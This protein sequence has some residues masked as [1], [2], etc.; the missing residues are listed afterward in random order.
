MTKFKKTRDQLETELGEQMLALRASSKAFDEG[1]LWEHKRLATSLFTLLHDYPGGRSK[2]LLGQLQLKGQVKFISSVVVPGP[3]FPGNRVIAAASTLIVATKLSN[4]GGAEY[5]PLLNNHPIANERKHLSFPRWY[6]EVIFHPLSGI[7]LTRKNMIFT[8][9]SQDG[10]SHVDGH[11]TD[12]QYFNFS[13][14]GDPSVSFTRAGDGLFLNHFGH[15]NG[16]PI[17]NGIP[18]TMRQ[19][20]WEVDH[21]LSQIGL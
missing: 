5:M 6:D 19:I 15:A 10:G 16:T 11:I 4:E 21:S 12:E 8:I 13:Q 20:A 14:R 1:N 3:F 17:K 2:S 7:T 18:A 9:R